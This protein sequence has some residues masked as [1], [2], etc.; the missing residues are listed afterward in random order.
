MKIFTILIAATSIALTLLLLVIAGPHAP[1]PEFPKG[2]HQSVKTTTDPAAPAGPSH[3]A[4]IRPRSISPEESH[5]PPKTPP[6]PMVSQVLS[7]PVSNAGHREDG[8]DTVSPSSVIT[9][10]DN[11]STTTNDVLA[12]DRA[13]AKTLQRIIEV[14][15]KEENK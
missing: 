15:N 14:L 11:P 2:K 6:T 9:R 4:A 7:R 8:E 10:N 1:Q 13:A 12:V 5:A 3:A